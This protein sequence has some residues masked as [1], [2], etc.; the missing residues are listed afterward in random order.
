MRLHTPNVRT[1]S[2]VGLFLLL[3]L[4][5]QCVSGIMISFSLISEPMLIPLSRDEEDI[6][7]LYT[8]DFFWIHER[9]V[10]LIFLLLVTHLLKKI[11][12]MSFSERQ[13]NAWKSGSFI[14]LLIHGAIFF[15][16]VLCCTHLSDI[17]L[18]IAANIINTLT[19]KYGKFYWF[20]FT[21]QTLNTDTI[22]RSMY[23]HYIL[24]LLC[25]FFGIIHALLMHYDYKDSN[26]FDGN[27][28]EVEWQDLIFKKELFKFF[29]ILVISYLYGK[30][31]YKNIEPLNYEI[32]M[33]GDIGNITDVRFLGV[34]PHWYFRSYMGW[35]LLCPHHYIGVFGLIFL[36]LSIYFQPNL[37]RGFMNFSKNNND[38]FQKPEISITHIF[39]FTVFCMCVFYTNS[40]LPYGRFFNMIGGNDALLIAFLYIF[41]YLN[42]SVHKLIYFIFN[43]S[44]SVKVVK[45]S[46]IAIF[47]SKKYK[48]CSVKI[49]DRL[50]SNEK[51]KVYSG[52][53]CNILKK[54][55]NY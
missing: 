43:Y 24:G 11:F 22:I 32:F 30:F 6:E 19:F 17:T 46:K 39:L 51:F 40:F 49:L 14:F 12:T 36:M 28:V 35:L 55:K 38:I 42:G 7:D 25:V 16:L 27:D 26:F 45:K 48:E 47:F 33:W 8:D 54:I 41:L 29:K 53:Y 9:G 20:L 50:N 44:N 23:I 1:I 4:I 52:M 37:K 10:D 34:A 5:I 15:G 3:I 2:L 13:E 18:T 31:F 21:D